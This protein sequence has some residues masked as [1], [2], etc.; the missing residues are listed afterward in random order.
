MVQVMSKFNE[1]TKMFKALSEIK[2]KCKY[3]GHINTIPVFLDKKP[4]GHC[5]KIINNNSKAYF[6]YNLIKEL[7]KPR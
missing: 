7:R 3:C 4:C 1:D 5:K 6:R 2:V